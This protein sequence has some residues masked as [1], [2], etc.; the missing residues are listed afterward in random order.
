MKT[1]KNVNLLNSSENEYSKS[2]K[3]KKKK[4]KEWY[5]IDND[6][7]GNYSHENPIKF[8]T[9]SIEW[10]HC[11]YADAYVFVVG[12]IADTGGNA[13]TKVAFKN[14]APFNKCRTEINR[15]FVDE[16]NFVNIAMPMYN[17]IEYSDNYSDTS[18]NLWQSKEMK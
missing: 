17:L 16:S 3:K 7:Q 11:D 2:S 6:S 18:R 4:R 9:K 5:V 15:T 1:Q 12:N 13:N 10:N 14:F 8:L